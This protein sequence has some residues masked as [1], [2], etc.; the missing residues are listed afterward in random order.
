MSNIRAGG[1]EDL[2]TVMEIEQAA[3]HVPL[4]QPQE[5][6]KSIKLIAKDWM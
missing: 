2:D 6:V 5:L 1:I 4:D 3:H